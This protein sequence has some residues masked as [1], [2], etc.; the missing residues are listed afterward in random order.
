MTEEVVEVREQDLLEMVLQSADILKNPML[1]AIVEAAPTYHQVEKYMQ[2]LGWPPQLVARVSAAVRF[3]IKIIAKFG[4]ETWKGFTSS[5]ADCSALSMVAELGEPIGGYHQKA[6]PI[7][8]LRFGEVFVSRKDWPWFFGDFVFNS[9]NGEI[10]T[11]DLSRDNPHNYH[12]EASWDFGISSFIG[13]DLFK[14]STRELVMSVGRTQEGRL[15]AFEQVGEFHIASRNLRMEH[16][17]QYPE[18]PAFY[19]LVR[20]YT[21]SEADSEAGREELRILLRND[22]NYN[23]GARSIGLSGEMSFRKTIQIGRDLV[24]TLSIDYTISQELGLSL[25]RTQR[26]IVSAGPAR[27]RAAVDV[28]Q[29]WAELSGSLKPEILS[30]SQQAEEIL[31]DLGV[32]ILVANK[33]LSLKTLLTREHLLTKDARLSTLLL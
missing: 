23:S 20:V 24:K 28:A 14:C 6:R 26:H 18:Y 30:R 33:K 4:I 25:D 22:M 3:R 16:Q 27:Y 19:K 8:A 29:S 13:A 12:H 15:E 11:L 5:S 21:S 31:L 7:S 17:R 2:H 10:T 1:R 9:H 32:R